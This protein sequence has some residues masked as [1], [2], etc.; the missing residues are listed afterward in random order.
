MEIQSDFFNSS[1]NS[2]PEEGPIDPFCVP[3]IIN[4]AEIPT[5]EF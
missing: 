3:L 4:D 5:F 1:E 2:L